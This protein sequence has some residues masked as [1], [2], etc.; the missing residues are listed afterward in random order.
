MLFDIQTNNLFVSGNSQTD[1]CL[2]DKECNCDSDSCPSAYCK[3]AESLTAEKL[4]AAAVEKTVKCC[5]LICTCIYGDR[6]AGSLRCCEKTNCKSSPDTVKAVYCDRT[7]GVIN[8]ELVIK[9]PYTERNQ[10]S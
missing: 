8:V 2:D 3:N 7:N 1:S 6:I 5:E 9:E 10:K 4:E